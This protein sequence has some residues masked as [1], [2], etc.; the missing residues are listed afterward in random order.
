MKI[1]NFTFTQ[2]QTVMLKW[3]GESFH[4]G[5]L[6]FCH[7]RIYFCHNYPRKH[8]NRSPDLLGY[9]GSWV[10]KYDT[11][12]GIF[13]EDVECIIPFIEGIEMHSIIIDH[14]LKCALQFFDTEEKQMIELLLLLKT[15][16]IEKYNQ[17]TLSEKP[18]FVRLTGKTN[19]LKSES[20]FVT[21]RISVEI[22][23]S[24]L[25]RKCSNEL[26]ESGQE[27]A[28]AYFIS[29]ATIEKI[30][31]KLV[32]FQSGDFIKHEFLSGEAFLE[33]YN[34]SNYAQG[35]GSLRKSCMNDKP[36]LL[37]LYVLNPNQVSVAVFKVEDKIVGRSIIWTIGDKKY[38][39]R[40]YYSQDWIEPHISKTLL[41]LGYSSIRDQ[42]DNENTET[43]FSVELEKLP[44]LFPYL[45]TFY[46]LCFDSPLC[47]PTLFAGD[48]DNFP[49][50]SYYRLLNTDGTWRSCINVRR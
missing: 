5:A 35:S 7:D 3:L 49:D 29:D 1:G 15:K 50:G 20:E 4:K 27:A 19:Y 38:F 47:R 45:D 30:N 41:D 40:I 13:T 44:Q 31:N 25:L 24:R 26:Q 22:K 33:A 16:P 42:F 9:D 21:K 39:D 43:F 17:I 6:N 11:E 28:K 12:A 48:F 23:L 32:S 18:G 8:G 34:S 46:F 37:Q 36:D 10:F 2:G 14:K